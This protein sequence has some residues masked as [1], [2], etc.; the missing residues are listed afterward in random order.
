MGLDM[1][2]YSAPKIEGMELDEIIKANNQLSILENEDRE[3]YLKVKDHIKQF[4]KFG[5]KWESLLTQQIYWRK[6]NHIHYWFVENVQ[7]GEDQNLALSPVEKEQLTKL[8]LLCESILEHNE[9]PD[10][11]LPTM[12]GP[13]FG[14]LAYDEF[15]FHE[16]ERTYHELKRILLTSFLDENYVMYQ[17]FW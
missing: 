15:Y 11:T 13:F 9:S 5:H 3:T 4:E 14:S 12:P 6:A 17:S 2:L 10:E 16:T 7:G 8:Y 1:H